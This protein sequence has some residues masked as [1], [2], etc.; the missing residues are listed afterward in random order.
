MMTSNN[1]TLN[2]LKSKE[3][4]KYQDYQIVFDKV[5]SKVCI[6]IN[7]TL[8]ADVESLFLA[9]PSFYNIMSLAPVL[10]SLYS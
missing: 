8:M 2:E 5:V 6:Y 1:K 4:S 7:S 9:N 3:V 10:D